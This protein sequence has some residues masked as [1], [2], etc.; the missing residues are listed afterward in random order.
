MQIY[1]HC[2]NDIFDTHG[3][4]VSSR[5]LLDMYIKLAIYFFAIMSMNVKEKNLCA[6][7]AINR[8]VVAA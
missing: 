7:S 2:I 6:I 3:D 8:V 1:R 4:G 5:T